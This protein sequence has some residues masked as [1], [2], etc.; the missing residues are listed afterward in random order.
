MTA[1]YHQLTAAVAGVTA[2]KC[3]EIKA[4]ALPVAP[5]G[6]LAYALGACST[7]PTTG[8][9]KYTQLV[10]EDCVSSSSVACE[11]Y[12]AAYGSTTTK[13]EVSYISIWS[14]GTGGM[15]CK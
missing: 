9:V 10:K 2:A 6:T 13:E 7:I 5:T 12:L 8:T 14:L 15:T 3:T 11:S 4:D 1:T